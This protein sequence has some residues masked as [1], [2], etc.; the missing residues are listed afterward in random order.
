MKEVLRREKKFLINQKQLYR[1]SYYFSQVMQEDPH[2]GADGYQIRSVYFDTLL[3]RDFQE[4]EDGTEIRRKIRLRNYGPKSD[5]GVL[6]MKQKQG[7]YQKKRSLK[8][9]KE[10]AIE[11]LKGNYSVL[12][13]YG[14]PF[15]IEMFGFMNIHCYRPKS[16]VEYKRKAFIAKE[17]KIRV[18]FDHNI[19]AT[20][21]NFDIFSIGLLQYPVFPSDLVILEVKYNGFLLSYIKDLLKSV[22]ESELSVSK[23][24]L[25]RGVS[26]HY[27]Y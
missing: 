5:F 18:T 19:I 9:R 7:A 24:A 12:L 4:K 25:S 2:N 27:C 6:E 13:T 3:D 14:E 17:N 8:I 15:A 16:V 20:E 11:L 23:Y 1:L 21:S 10:D 26:K 22:N